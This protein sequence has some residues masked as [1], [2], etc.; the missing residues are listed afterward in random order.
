SL[1]DN[2]WNWPGHVDMTLRNSAD[3]EAGAHASATATVTV[4]SAAPP[5]RWLPLRASG[6]SL[7]DQLAQHIAA[8]IQNH[9]FRVGMRLPS[10]R[11]MAQE[12]GVS[13]FTVVQAYDKLAA[14]GLIQSRK[15]SGFYVQPAPPL[16]ATAVPVHGDAGSETT[17]D[18]SFLL[19]SMF[20][21]D[22]G[23]RTSGNAGLLPSEWLDEGMVAAVV[24]N[25]GRSL[26]PSVI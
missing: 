26:G 14:M 15:G 11:A 16:V 9:G 17:F 18:T 8:Q 3:T 23:Q 2:I 10:V 22:G 1:S 25:V 19:R 4:S 13:R 21:T 5:E 24:R 6:V 7:V 20:R 12:A